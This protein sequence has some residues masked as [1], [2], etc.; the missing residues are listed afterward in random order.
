MPNVRPLGK[1]WNISKHRFFELYHYCLQYNEWKDILNYKVATVK[2][3]QIS[4]MPRA[5][6]G[7]SDPTADLGIDRAELEHKCK[8]IEDAA[9][10]VDELLYDYIIKAVTN[11]GI[12]YNYLSTVMGIPCS[13]N[14]WY[15][16][17]RKFYWI[18]DRKLKGEE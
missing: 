9:Q 16:L 7:K 8:V 5:L 18:L 14:T 2:S 4:D 13:H 10:A 15:K 6:G 1:K 12:T 17:R 11:E 3:P